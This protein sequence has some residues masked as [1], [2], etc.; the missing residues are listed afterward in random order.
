MRK[1]LKMLSPM[2][3]AALLISCVQ[4]VEQNVSISIDGGK[5]VS[6]VIQYSNN[7]SRN[8]GTAAGEGE[9]SPEMLAALKE[10]LEFKVTLTMQISSADKSYNDSASEDYVVDYESDTVN[11]D[12]PITFINVPVGIQANISA[13][14]TSKIVIKDKTA[15]ANL[16]QLWGMP[17]EVFAAYTEEQLSQML[18]T[19]F[20][21]GFSLKGSTELTVKE[22]DNPVTLTMELVPDQGGSG[23]G[24]EGG[25]GG[26][27]SGEGGGG[28]VEEPE[29]DPIGISG[30]VETQLPQ[31]LT[32]KINETKS[33]AKLYLNK[34]NIV[35]KLLDKDGKD[36]AADPENA[37][38]AGAI[39]EYKLY[40]K[41]TLIPTSSTNAVA[42]Y[43][44]ESGKV[45]L[46]NLP[47]SGMYQLYVQAKPI[48]SGYENC[49]LVSAVFDLPIDYAYYSYSVNI[50]DDNYLMIAEDD[51]ENNADFQ[52]FA[53]IMKNKNVYLK[54]SG[55][56]LTAYNNHLC[57]LKNVSNDSSYKLYLD[58][59]DLGSREA[60]SQFYGS[61]LKNWTKLNGIILP[62]V[63]TEIIIDETG[64]ENPFFYGCNE[65]TSVEFPIPEGWYNTGLRLAGSDLEEYIWPDTAL[66][67]VSDAATNADDFKTTWK[68]LYRKTE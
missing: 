64:D 18:I 66:L 61:F 39:W 28:V 15:L 19:D 24:G 22:G 48:A 67:D 4:T 68:Y 60:E 10:A 37:S 58:L 30:S 29:E 32:I 8:A 40:Y 38:T 23:A 45:I 2:I 63:V 52:A 42:Y 51:C 34:G 12:K 55:Q 56:V 35:F 53:N 33:D 3:F 41:N 65:L 5:I 20:D 46:Q 21:W 16:Y 14:I 13:V 9:L 62:K 17:E 31:T 6:R 44:Y 26:G 25:S 50:N 43:S 1:F 7:K 49:E 27:G 11:V 59:T 47:V 36:L 57:H 54:L